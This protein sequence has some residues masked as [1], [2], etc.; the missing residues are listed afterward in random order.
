MCIGIGEGGRSTGRWNYLADA[1]QGQETEQGP[2]CVDSHE[3]CRADV[4]QMCR[5]ASKFVWETVTYVMVTT[6]ANLGVG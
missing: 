2:P 4:W 6:V 3:G 1:E 5:C